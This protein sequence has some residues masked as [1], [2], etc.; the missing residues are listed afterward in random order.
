M[1]LHNMPKG[2]TFGVKPLA[3][4]WSVWG[5]GPCYTLFEGGLNADEATALFMKLLLREAKL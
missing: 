3:G 2:T 4:M 5:Y 1:T